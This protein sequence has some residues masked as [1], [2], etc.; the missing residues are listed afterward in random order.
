M[1][2]TQEVMYIA[3]ERLQEQRD[4][5]ESLQSLFYYVALQEAHKHLKRKIKYR[6][7]PIKLDQAMSPGP[8]FGASHPSM[9]ITDALA[10]NDLH[11]AS[12][13]H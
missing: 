2:M 12:P 4:A 8:L 3:F 6:T 9:P 11:A 5:K 7:I 13:L 1:Q 10:S